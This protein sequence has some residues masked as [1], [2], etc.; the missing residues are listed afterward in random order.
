[1]RRHV[2]IDMSLKTK[3]EELQRSQP[4][5]KM[6]KRRQTLPSYQFRD[7]IISSIRENPVRFSVVL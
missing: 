4:Y 3:E 5:Q 7:E 1:M 6:L 2:A